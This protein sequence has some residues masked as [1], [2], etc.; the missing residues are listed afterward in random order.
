MTFGMH[1]IFFDTAH[2]FFLII[3]RWYDIYSLNTFWIVIK[4]V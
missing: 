1:I 2:K 4:I 3:K